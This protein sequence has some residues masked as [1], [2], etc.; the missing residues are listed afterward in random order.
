MP[1]K[2]NWGIVT[3]GGIARKFVA[4]LKQSRTGRFVAVGARKFVDAEK[5][6][7]DF[8]GARAYGSYDELLADVEVQAVYIGTPHPGHKEWAIKAVAAGK[9][10]L[11]EKPLTLTLK[12][13]LE[14]IAAAKK[15]GVLLMEAYMY[16]FHPQTRKVVELVRS[17]V[18]GELNLIRASFNVVCTFDPEHRMFKK[19]LGGGSILDLGCY[20]ISY[21]RHIAGAAA[22]TAFAEPLEFHGTGRLHPMVGTDDF[23]TA[24]AKFPNGLLAELSCG[25]TV[26]NDNAVEIHGTKGWLEV[27]NPFTP[28]LGGRTEGIFLHRA[29]AAAPEQ[30]SIPS[31]GVGLYAYEADAVADALERGE[32]EV[33][34][35][36][37]ADTIGTATLLDAWLTSVGLN[38]DY[39]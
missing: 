3:T 23:A 14:V 4:D 18:I 20:P 31:P 8:G 16:R 10:V 22:D 13:T 11:C 15:H 19:S 25:S 29:G 33:A 7:A 2:L 27:P 26:K 21:S 30:I 39:S 1:A 17:G 36:S 28:G 37:W 38:Y 5:F 12:D 35:A 34:L 9:H 24:V 6:A 32:R